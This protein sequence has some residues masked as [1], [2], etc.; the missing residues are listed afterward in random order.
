MLL[1]VAD[2]LGRNLFETPVP[3]VS[4]FVS[5][6]IVGCVF[7]PLGAT[8]REGKL[9]RA[10]FLAEPL[11]AARPRLA[12]LLELVFG[13]A[14]LAMLWIA[15]RY[16]WADALSAWREGE[17]LG[18]VGA[19]QIATWPFKLTVALGCTL[20]LAELVAGLVRT[21]LATE[22]GPVARTLVTVLAVLVFA[23]AIFGSDQAAAAGFD[24]VG[25]GLAALAALLVLISLGM[26][27]V[28][29]LMVTSFVGIWLVRD[30]IFVAENSVGIS[31]ASAVRSQ[32]FGVIPLFVMM[33]LLLD[34]AGV[35]RDAFQIMAILVRR[36]SGGL[37]VATV[38]AN[39]IFASITGSSIAS[40]TVFSRIAVPPMTEAG[41]S[42]RFSL[43]IVAGSSVLG[44][45]IPPSLLMIVYGLL[46]ESSI[47]DLFIAGIVPG[48]LLTAAFAAIIML[49]ARFAPGFAGDTRAGGLDDPLTGGEIATRLLPVV[50]IVVLVMGGIYGGFFSPTEAGAAG[51]AGALLIALARRSLDW[52]EFRRLAIETGAITAGLLFLMIAANIYG[53]M[54]AM[55]TIPNVMAGFVAELDLTLVGLALLYALIV[56]A[57]GMI[58][59]SVSIM[60]I[61][62][63]IALPIIEP[64]GADLIW[65]GIVTVIA[66]EIG[67]LTPP[68]GLSVYVVKGSLPEGYATLGDIFIAAAP[69]VLTMAA[70]TTLIILVPGIALVLL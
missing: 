40:A 22:G 28:F 38:G 19:Y 24:R 30:M 27:I 54:L 41:Y 64:M 33:G 17:F 13:L 63:P 62:L 2:I 49:M 5:Y 20:A 37:G 61:V 56:V 67:L 55:S 16:L 32:G 25:V 39:A 21:A 1:V 8:I 4:D 51:A 18:A 3:G 14:A 23:A 44:M 47:G 52:S 11:A 59:D 12:R 42:K 9:V 53:R 31:A 34:R 57:L 69:F 15:A 66:I 68:F 58:L 6:A 10:V 60:L 43:G 7:L 65:F 45:L 48:L 50:A 36:I 29:G 70:V 35:G 26:P 46:S